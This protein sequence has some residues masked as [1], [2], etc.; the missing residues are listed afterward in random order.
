M[1]GALYV[2]KADT[3]TALALFRQA[4]TYNRF[5]RLAFAKLSELELEPIPAPVYFERLR[6]MLTENPLDIEAAM[7]R[8]QY[9]EKIRL[10]AQAEQ[11]YK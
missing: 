6:L 10:Y 11:A 2:E 3:E 1:L 4:Y 9:A 7:N 5:N 8:A